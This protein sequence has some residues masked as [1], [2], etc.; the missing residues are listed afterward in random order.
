M[1]ALILGAS[2]LVGEKLLKETLND[3]YY[4]EVT[5]LVR[6][7]LKVVDKKLK[8]VV[9]DYD[10]M[11]K[12][13][14]EFSVDHVYCCLG[15]T[16]K[17][18]KTK[19][20]FKKVDYEYPL[21]AAK[22]SKQKNVKHYVLVSAIGADASSPIFYTR[23]KGQ[24]EEAIKR[25]GLKSFTA[26]RP[27]LLLGNR[28]ENRLGEKLG[29]GLAKLLAPAFVGPLKKFRAVDVRQVAR[30]MI[31]AAKGLVVDAPIAIKRYGSSSQR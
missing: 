18:A 30:C 11:E 25:L 22:L 17:K 6:R 16:L 4:H 8:E 5:V 24:V 13:S 2:G 7:P 15:T 23:I 28:Y 21:R 20:N 9:V 12:Y 3:D 19:N 31:Q 14:E 1:K 29:I 10:Q 27:S 26:L